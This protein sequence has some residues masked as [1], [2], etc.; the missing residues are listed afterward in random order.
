MNPQETI[1]RSRIVETRILRTEC[2][3]ERPAERRMA[4]YIGCSPLAAKNPPNKYFR[5]A[6]PRANLPKRLR[7]FDL[8]IAPALVLESLSADFREV[9][10]LVIRTRQ[11]IDD[12]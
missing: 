1:P 6:T 12:C 9:L 4:L 5:E 2:H 10:G 3:F 7:E 8:I 11:I